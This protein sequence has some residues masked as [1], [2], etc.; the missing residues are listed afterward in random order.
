MST[1]DE[2][3][4]AVIMVRRSGYEGFCGERGTMPRKL[5]VHLPVDATPKEIALIMTTAGEMLVTAGH[6]HVRQSR[7]IR[8]D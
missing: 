1:T 3:T 6:K 4:H 5:E 7:S 8:L 2:G